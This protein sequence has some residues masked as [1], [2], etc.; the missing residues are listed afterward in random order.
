M[1]INVGQLFEKCTHCI[2]CLQSGLKFYGISFEILTLIYTYYLRDKLLCNYYS[3]EH[4]LE[5]TVRVKMR[6]VFQLATRGLYLSRSIIFC[7][8]MF[9]WNDSAISPVNK[10]ESK[11]E[12]MILST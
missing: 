9:K 5:V 3:K 4:Y 2:Y 12:T 11:L 6:V 10:V 1:E 8:L 7:F